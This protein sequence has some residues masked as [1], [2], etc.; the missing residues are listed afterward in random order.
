MKHL[1]SIIFHSLLLAGFS[2]GAVEAV[3]ISLNANHTADIHHQL[4]ASVYAIAPFTLIGFVFAVTCAVLTN[5][6]QNTRAVTN[7]YGKDSQE[8]SAGGPRSSVFTGIL[9]VQLFVG[10]LFLIA[11]TSFKSS[12][13]DN[14]GLLIAIA[15]PVLGVAF[16]YGWS[17]LRMR[18]S[19]FSSPKKER[20]ANATIAI[21][22]CLGI[23]AP[24]IL[25]LQNESLLT[26]LG[27]N[28]VLF[29]CGFPLLSVVFGLILAR[30]PH[31]WLNR[32]STRRMVVMLLIICS[33][34]L[35]DLITDLDR[36]E[37]VK[38]A[39]LYDSIVLGPL[40]MVTQP[41]FDRDNDGY[42]KY[43]GGGDCDDNDP[44]VYPG[45]F[46]IPRNGVDDDCF[47]G[48]APG[49]EA[50]LNVRQHHAS[51][52]ARRVLVKH[53]NIIHITVDTLTAEHLGFMGYDRKTSPTL[54]E[55]AESG[56]HFLWA[57]SQGPQ[58]RLSV[59]SM[60]VGKYFS[61]LPRTTPLWPRLKDENET[62]AEVL[63]DNGYQTAG[64][65]SHRFF[66][67]GYGLNQGF[68]YWD[69][70][71]VE[72]YQTDI[73]KHVTGHLVT[74]KAIDWLQKHEDDDPPFYLWLHYFDPHEYYQDHPDIDFGTT[75]LD[76]YDEEILYTD[77]QLAQLM[78]WLRSSKLNTSTY[79]I[80]HS[81]HGEGFGRHGYK[82]HGQH[83][84]NDQVH[85]PLIINGPGLEPRQIET[86]VGL[87]DLNPTIREMAGVPLDKALQGVSL[88]PYV[89]E[90]EPPPHP[91]VFIEM[92]KDPT[93][94]DRRVMVSWPYKL[95]F[96]ITFSEY[97]LYDLSV[98]PQEEKNLVKTRPRVFRQLQAE[99]RNWMSKG[100]KPITPSE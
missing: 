40:V 66:L 92:L 64:I 50:P 15:T 5:L 83:L 96:G 43:L 42:A 54:D 95:Q 9:A 73:P 19:S 49:T 63:R 65:P 30:L 91:P 68:S 58:T 86:P 25:G 22:A 76:L 32:S 94:S 62:L 55:L 14:Y 74:E 17:F 84:Y 3:Y 88:I 98:D 53:P 4:L 75:V 28:S 87:I 81:D 2:L 18:L 51:D 61:E 7:P 69:L 80:V 24:A 77:R 97:S 78:S 70:S 31:S 47:Q 48:D 82:R 23:L 56:V 89:V 60:F 6:W 44:H 27:A 85:V 36:D 34:S 39:V 41:L 45:A 1:P 13:R 72:Q 20:K 33:A 38:S 79:V 52:L 11:Y 35:T 8:H 16:F 29:V 10:S 100:V 26:F 67:P 57:F 12:F 21:I 59:P 71:I 93:H 37:G 90:T 99:L 46:E